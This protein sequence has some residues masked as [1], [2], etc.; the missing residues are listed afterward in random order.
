VLQRGHGRLGPRIH[1]SGGVLLQGHDRHRPGELA[2]LSTIEGTHPL[3]VIRDHQHDWLRWSAFATRARSSCPPAFSAPSSDSISV[4]GNPRCRNWELTLPWPILRWV[5]FAIGARLR[6][7]SRSR[8]AR[9]AS[10]R[11]RHSDRDDAILVRRE[12]RQ[13]PPAQRIRL[14][15][16][17]SS[18]Q[19]HLASRQRR[20]RK[21]GWMLPDQ[22]TA[23]TPKP[24]A[25]TPRATPSGTAMPAPA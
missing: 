1:C 9:G 12:G 25:T 14:R 7:R 19:F 18:E 8:M 23:S 6:R 3:L 10:P 15:Q 13:H 20:P 17:G 5:A 2:K 4:Q 24:P 16:Q 21:D 11:R 22:P